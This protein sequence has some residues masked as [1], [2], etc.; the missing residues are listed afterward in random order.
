MLT[1]Y[2]VVIIVFAI[3]ALLCDAHPLR[4]LALPVHICEKLPQLLEQRRLLFFVKRAYSGQ[5]VV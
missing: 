5:L 2:W 1:M 4:M 3:F